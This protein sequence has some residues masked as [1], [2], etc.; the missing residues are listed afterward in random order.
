MAIPQRTKA[1]VIRR[2]QVACGERRELAALQ[3]ALAVKEAV[4]REGGYVSDRFWGHG[5][6]DG[7]EA[8]MKEAGLLET[9]RERAQRAK[10]GGREE[11]SPNVCQFS[12][13]SL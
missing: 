13:S 7:L 6:A 3:S 9:G 8:A 12:F 4:W 10:E 2:R 11:H 5:V 1:N